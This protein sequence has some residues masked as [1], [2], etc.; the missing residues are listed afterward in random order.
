MP[1]YSSTVRAI[2][3][4]R[5]SASSRLPSASSPPLMWR[6]A[7]GCS[8]TWCSAESTKR[9]AVSWNRGFRSRN[10]CITSSSKITLL[11]ARLSGGGE[12][13]NARAALALARERTLDRLGHILHENEVQLL[14]HFIR[15]L[16]QVRLVPSGQDDRLDPGLRGRDQLL[17]DPAD[18]EHV[19]AQRDLSGHRDLAPDRALGEE[20]DECDDE[21]DAG[22]RPVLRRRA[23]RDVHVDISP[24]EPAVRDP[25]PA[26]VRAD[27]A[28]GRLGRLLHHVPEVARQVDLALA[29]IGRASW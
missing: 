4:N 2:G 26:G 6:G 10:R 17:L 18:R 19:P 29:Q 20:G 8:M 14:L 9:Y 1:Q 16:I 28:E 25:Q 21:R 7:G 3:P 27:I 15:Y 23:G 12:P 24:I 22:R 5:S 13:S 11:I